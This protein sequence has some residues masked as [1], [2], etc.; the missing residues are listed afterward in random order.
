MMSRL[1][2]DQILYPEPPAQAGSLQRVEA[3]SL[4][5]ANVGIL[6][7]GKDCRF[8]D[9]R[10]LPRIDL[11]RDYLPAEIKRQ[12]IGGK[13]GNR[14]QHKYGPGELVNGWSSSR[15]KT[16]DSRHFQQIGRAHV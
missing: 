15:L 11:L 6:W 10:Y 9:W 1:E 5:T 16:I 4:I 13:Q 7:R 8:S 14:I 2:P 3:N 12:L